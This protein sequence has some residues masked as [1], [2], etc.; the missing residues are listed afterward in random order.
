VL[1][2]LAI[3][4]TAV[5]IWQFL[6]RPTE[7]ALRLSGRVEGTPTEVEAKMSGRVESVAVREGDRV[8]Q[9]Q[10]LVRLADTEI[11]AALQQA[12]ARIVAASQQEQQVRNQ[13]AMIDAQ[14]QSVQQFSA[15]QPQPDM[16]GQV[17]SA[18]APLKAQLQQAESQLNLATLNRDRYAQLWQEGAIA[19][20]QFDQA[21]MGYESAQATVT[22]IKQQIDAVQNSLTAQPA[23]PNSA[24]R[25]TALSGLMQQRQQAIAQV[26]IA[27]TEIKTAQTA[28]QQIQAKLA[29]LAVPSP[30]DGV[31]TARRVEPGMTVGNGKTLLSVTNLDSVYLRGFIPED[32]LDKVRVGQQAKVYLDSSPEQPLTAKVAAIDL[33]AATSPEN[34]RNLGEPVVSVKLTINNLTGYAKPGMPAK[35]EIIL[36]TKE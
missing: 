34:T 14:I 2:G 27:Q 22:A 13:I 33:P 23:V 32:K 35:A 4:G 16:R 24:N 15:M 9:G 18:I 1:L 20:Q 12:E 29:N 3:A 5:G 10:V 28:R 17:E 11:T 36:D 6:S 7:T 25:S 19:K 21:Q 31:V 8:N 30:L 26:Q